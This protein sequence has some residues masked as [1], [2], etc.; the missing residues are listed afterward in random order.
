MT[1]DWLAERDHV[2]SLTLPDEPK[3]MIDLNWKIMFLSE[4][5][6]DKYTSA[7]RRTH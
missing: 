6:R 4:V 7:D 2:Q 3:N 5:D 1:P